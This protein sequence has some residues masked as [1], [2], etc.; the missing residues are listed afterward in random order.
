LRLAGRPGDAIPHYAAAARLDPHDEIARVDG[1][2][3]LVDLGRYGEARRVLT[4][5]LDANPTSGLIAHAL[6]RLLAAS[7]DLSLRDG[8]R[9]VDLAQR[10]DTAAPSSLHAETLALAL[11]EAGRCGEAADAQGRA[12]AA[13]Q[14]EG[15]QARAAA[16]TA[17]RDAYAAGP[18]CRPGAP[19]PR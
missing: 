2:A 1:A 3:T 9:A 10:V 13:A 6:A 18:P 5:A 7:P 19:A 15:D 4:D 14:K 12:I 8:A 16:L 11:A 17:A